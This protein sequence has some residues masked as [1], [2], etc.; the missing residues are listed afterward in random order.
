MYERARLE[1]EKLLQLHQEKLEAAT[2]EAHQIIEEGRADALRLQKEITESI[3]N[4]YV[5]AGLVSRGEHMVIMEKE[6][7]K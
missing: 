7:S 6:A 5:L 4:G 2:D 1:G 3:R